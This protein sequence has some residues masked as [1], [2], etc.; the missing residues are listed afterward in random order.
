MQEGIIIFVQATQGAK[1]SRLYS[2][3]S[4]A[5]GHYPDWYMHT[6]QMAPTCLQPLWSTHH[7]SVFASVQA[8]HDVSQN[9]KML[10]SGNGDVFVPR[11]P[12]I[13]CASLLFFEL[14]L[15]LHSDQLYSNLAQ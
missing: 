7:S 11:L 4:D 13:Q 1:S 15:S 14:C 2:G 3:I 12:L 5:C 10:G 9:G 6:C 8:S